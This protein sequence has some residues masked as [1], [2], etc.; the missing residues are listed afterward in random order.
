MVAEMMQKPK[1]LLYV[2]YSCYMKF[3]FCYIFHICVICFVIYL[4]YIYLY[5][6]LFVHIYLCIYIYLFLFLQYLILNLCDNVFNFII[7]AMQ[8]VYYKKILIVRIF[9]MLYDIIWFPFTW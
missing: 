6:Y 1:F 5:I 8:N 3:Y 2:L 7:C 4:L 9:F